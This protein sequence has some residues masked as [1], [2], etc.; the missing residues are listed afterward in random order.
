MI[1]AFAAPVAPSAARTSIALDS[2]I[3]SAEIAWCGACHD[4]PLPRA[5]ATIAGYPLNVS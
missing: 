4:T 3:F 2:T 1:T 5:V